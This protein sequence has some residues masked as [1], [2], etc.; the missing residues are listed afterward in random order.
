MPESTPGAV[1]TG[2][3]EAMGPTE[4]SSESTKGP[5]IDEVD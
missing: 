1:P 3:T 5:T 4:E 2:S